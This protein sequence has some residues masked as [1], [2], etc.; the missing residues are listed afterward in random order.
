MIQLPFEMHSGLPV[1]R[2]LTIV[3]D[4]TGTFNAIGNYSAAPQDFFY[5]IPVGK[6]FSWSQL[7]ISISTASGTFNQADYGAISG[8]LTNGL[9]LYLRLNGTEVQILAAQVIKQNN[10]FYTLTFNVEKSIFA[11]TPQT[12]VSSF[13]LLKDY[14]N[15]ILLQAGDRI[16]VRCNDDFTS[17]SAHKFVARGILV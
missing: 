11:G 7:T 14:G 5:E 17:L 16:I 10:D 4:T 13:D 6:T 2:P 3:G 12:L 8:G 1:I 9:K 15:A